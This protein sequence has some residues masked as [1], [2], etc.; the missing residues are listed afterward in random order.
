MKYFSGFC[1]TGEQSLFEE[2]LKPSEYTIAGFSYGAILAFEEAFTCKDRID[3]LQLISP[4]F[5][6]DKETKF[7]KLQTLHFAKNPEAYKETFVRNV[8]YPAS[9]DLSSFVCEGTLEELST[10]LHYEWD[11]Q[12][13]QQLVDRGIE[14]EVYFGA[15]DK[16]ID[17]KS[18]REFFV[19]YATVY[20]D[21]HAG[22]ILKESI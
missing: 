22:H 21:K 6:Q 11:T 7:K 19:P 17:A 20:Y 12:R 1:L 16:I 4:A 8:V 2:V 13:L 18:A 3:T 9:C 15:H 5:F 14:I 10:L